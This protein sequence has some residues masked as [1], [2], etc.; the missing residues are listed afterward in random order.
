MIRI[1]SIA[2]V[3]VSIDPIPLRLVIAAICAGTL[4]TAVAMVSALLNP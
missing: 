4:A 1:E 2:P 3:P